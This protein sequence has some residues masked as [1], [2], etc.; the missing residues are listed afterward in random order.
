[1]RWLFLL[2]HQAVFRDMDAN[3]QNVYADN[4]EFNQIF[5][6]KRNSLFTRFKSRVALGA[7]RGLACRGTIGTGGNYDFNRDPLGHTPFGSFKRTARGGSQKGRK[8]H[9]ELQRQ[10]YSLDAP[11]WAGASGQSTLHLSGTWQGS[12]RVRSRFR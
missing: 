8:R 10:E 7:C 6:F 11:L 9:R 4:G 2:A 3:C 12:G 5:L 1:M